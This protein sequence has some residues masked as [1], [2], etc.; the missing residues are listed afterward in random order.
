MMILR[1]GR[2]S[3]KDIILKKVDD[4]FLSQKIGLVDK[5]KA[6]ENTMGFSHLFIL[7]LR[8]W[9]R[10]LGPPDSDSGPDLFDLLIFDLLLLLL[11]LDLLLQ[12]LLAFD[13]LLV[14]LHPSAFLLEP[15]LLNAQTL[16]GNVT[17]VDGPTAFGA[18]RYPESIPLRIVKL[19]L[20]SESQGF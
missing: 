19:V 6:I 3:A 4:F 13:L 11:P 17:F 2:S 7:Q 8:S 18:A 5:Q 16:R 1:G 9:P 10:G 14:H 20:T 15:T 12:H